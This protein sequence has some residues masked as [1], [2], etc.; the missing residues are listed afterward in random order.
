MTGYITIKIASEKWGIG[1]RR[2]NELCLQG[3]IEGAMKFG[4]TWAIPEDAN[5]PTDA[6]IKTGKYIKTKSREEK[7]DVH[8][9]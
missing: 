9:N 4:T 6:R 7:K 3:R 2:I 5:K 1:E 8:R